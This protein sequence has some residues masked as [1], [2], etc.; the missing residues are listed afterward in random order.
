VRV[1]IFD[2]HL[3]IYHGG[4]LQL[5]VARV[6]GRT[7]HRVE[8]RHLVDSMLRKPG[9]FRRYHYFD[10]FFP[11]SVFRDAFDVLDAALSRWQADVT[12]LR[13]LRLA[14]QTMESEVAEALRE[15]LD[16]GEV[17]LFEHIE[18]MVAPREP[19]LPVV[20]IPEVELSGYDDL[21]QVAAAEVA[22]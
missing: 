8:Y 2:G 22:R 14:A 18:A 3:E 6:R 16:S 19:L 11:T 5:R 4:A 9:A 1:R 7:G 21:I 13:I 15:T 12:Y 17:P 20:E 10:A